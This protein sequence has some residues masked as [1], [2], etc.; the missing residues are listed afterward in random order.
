MR[1]LIKKMVYQVPGWLGVYHA[2]R[3]RHQN[4]AVVLTYHGVVPGVPANRPRFEYRNFVTTAQFENQIRTMVKH[5]RP[6][7]V[8]DFYREDGEVG[9]GF[10]VT[11]DDGFVN[12]YRYAMPILKKYGVE[13]C[14]FIT[15]NLIGT[16]NFLWTEEVTR[17]LE[18]T[19][20]PA[21]ELTFEQPQTFAL[22]TREERLGASQQI[23]KK[24][25]LMGP[26][27]L[28][29]M[30]ADLREQLSDVAAEMSGE[31]EDRYLMM[32]WEEVRDMLKNGQ[33]IGSHTHNHP[34]LATLPE[35]MSFEEL[36]LSR[37]KI[38]EECQIPCQTLSYPNGERENFSPKIKEQLRELDYRCAFSQIPL[39]NDR[40]S[41]PYELRRFN[42]SLELP[43]A[44]MEARIAGL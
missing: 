16:R 5:Y 37:D 11:F 39:F 23:R 44:A 21:V 43:L 25:K 33:A 32:T 35:E 6:L 28:R 17:R 27:P 26:V 20:M 22:G 19:R 40:H 10:L 1:A 7:K 8:A 14:F 2:L 18:M 3:K 31:E 34:M 4:E 30:M 12:N 38:R 13:G 15:T 29:K 42:V 36:R 9:G 41:D 24:M